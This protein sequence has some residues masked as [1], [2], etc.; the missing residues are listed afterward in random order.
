MQL[1]VVASIKAGPFLPTSCNNILEEI[2]REEQIQDIHIPVSVATSDHDLTDHEPAAMDKSLT[3]H[4]DKQKLE[5]ALNKMTEKTC[6]NAAQK[7]KALGILWQNG[8]V[9]SLS[10]NKPTFTNKLTICMDMGTANTP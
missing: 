3:L 4:M 7:A 1:K 8:E 6:I 2:P 10:G 5:F 9:F